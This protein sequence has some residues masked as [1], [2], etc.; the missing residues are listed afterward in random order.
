MS[1]CSKNSAPDREVPSASTYSPTIL[2]RLQTTLAALAD[3]D[4]AYEADL[5]TVTKSGA[6]DAIKQ[7]VIRSLQQRQQVSRAPYIRQLAALHRKAVTA[8]L[9]APSV[10]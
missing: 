3:L 9:A 10:S 1:V 7:E 5:E 6:P 2:P 4:H 8:A